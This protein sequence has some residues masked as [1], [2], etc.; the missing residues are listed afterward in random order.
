MNVDSE[1]ANT[2]PLMEPGLFPCFTQA[3]WNQGP[4]AEMLEFNYVLN[5]FLLQIFKNSFIPNYKLV[6]ITL[7]SF[8]KIIYFTV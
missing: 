1:A 4:L 2:V 8:L 6:F 3:K 5:K 7:I